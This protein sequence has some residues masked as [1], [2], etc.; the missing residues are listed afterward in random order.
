MRYLGRPGI[1]FIPPTRDEHE[2]S[3][4]D[5]KWQRFYIPRL[6]ELETEN[7]MEPLGNLLRLKSAD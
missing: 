3:L 5:I 2:H 1:L 7:L 6:L 4:Q